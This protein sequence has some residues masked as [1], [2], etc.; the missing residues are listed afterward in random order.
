MRI[1]IIVVSTI[2]FLLLTFFGFGPVV[3]ADGSLEERLITAAIVII[4]MVGLVLGTKWSLKKFPK[5]K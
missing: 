2:L 5:N 1:F 4:L 3:F